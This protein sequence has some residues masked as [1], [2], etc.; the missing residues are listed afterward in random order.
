[1]AGAMIDLKLLDL[2]HTCSRCG[3]WIEEAQS[4]RNP[5]C[6]DCAG[7]QKVQNERKRKRESRRACMANQRARRVGAEGRF[8]PA[9]VRR[10]R[11]EQGN[12]C[13]Y[14]RC[15]LRTSGDVVDHKLPLS[16]G[17]RSDASNIHLTCPTCNREKGAR[18]HHEYLKARKENGED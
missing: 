2:E 11:R 3:T 14:C 9:D 13:A 5:L 4:V 16:R 6:A 17:G 1:M 12:R 18:S 15:D 7:S 8:Y 10:I